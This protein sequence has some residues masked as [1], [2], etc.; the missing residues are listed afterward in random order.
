M[1]AQVNTGVKPEKL[2]VLTSLRF[3]AAGLIVLHHSSGH[4]H[5]GSDINAFFPTYQA[6]SF[7]FVLS[8]FI[9]TYVYRDF[10]SPGS[11][12]RFF[13]ARIARVW[14][15][16]CVTLLLTLAGFSVW[17]SHMATGPGSLESFWLP[18]VSNLFMVQS[19]IP[20]SEFYYSFNAI[21]WSISTEFGFYLLFPLLL[22]GFRFNWPFK[23][24]GAFVFTIAVV[25]LL[26]YLSTTTGIKNPMTIFGVICINPLART[27]EFTSGMVMAMF[28][29]RIKH[30]YT[31]GQNAATLIEL[32]AL[33]AVLAGMSM[34]LSLQSAVFPYLG[35]PGKFWVDVGNTNVM[36]VAPFILVMA[37]S[38]GWISRVLSGPVFVFLGEISFSVYLLHQIILRAY[39]G[40]FEMHVTTPV[41]FSFGYYIVVVL[42]GSY[43]LWE[44]IEKPCRRLILSWGKGNGLSGIKSEVSAIFTNRRVGI[45]IL[46]LL[47]LLTPFTRLK[48]VEPGIAIVNQAHARTLSVNSIDGFSD[49][50][51]GTDFL[52]KGILVDDSE[53]HSIKLVW[54]SLE[55][56]R[57]KYRVAVHFLDQQG[58]IVSQADYYQS[59]RD[60]NRG[61][62]RKYT[63]WID[64]IDFSG[65]SANVRSIGLALFTESDMKLLPVSGG[66][67][68]WN[69]T[70]LIIPWVN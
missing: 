61:K 19:W 6:V 24:V 12:R 44:I 1:D 22:A 68:D 20:V 70:R 18:L 39:S 65:V 53:N 64:D 16:H 43:M 30:T 14:P 2:N 51:F 54:E 11:V 15:I 29:N 66:S 50:R 33:T 63:F 67:R 8:G 58:E 27:F 52:L 4:F 41:W 35:V 28:Y 13:I 48:P 56:V 42:L 23:W 45:S 60:D 57:L 10:D 38:K 34:N 49:I 9:L 46:V 7:F 36:F 5:F 69:N 55:T 17:F 32:T 26:H 21:S 31:P 40:Y 37:L 59:N 47:V 3:F 62:V 25:L